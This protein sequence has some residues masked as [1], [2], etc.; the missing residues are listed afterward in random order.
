[1]ISASRLT[2]STFGALAGIGGVLHGVGEVQQGNVR[3]DGLFIESWTEGPI[4][5]HMDGDP[6]ITIIPNMLATGVLALVVS[7]LLIVWAVFFVRRPRG[8][9]V[10]TV[11]S[12]AMLIVGG[13]V[14]PPVIGMLAGWPAS[15]IGPGVEAW[16]SRLPVRGRRVMA[17]AWPLVFAAATANGVFLFIGSTALLYLTAF[18]DSDLV[19]RSFYLAT[20]LMVPTTLC[21]IAHELAQ[22]H[23][24]PRASARSSKEARTAS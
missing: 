5:D 1:M 16:R 7:S 14:G 9:R 4:A 10:L 3:P 19:L 24:P 17:T 12:L 23:K 20:A 21:A 2:A 22:C 11:L 6:G 8:G 15:A 18:D 13:G